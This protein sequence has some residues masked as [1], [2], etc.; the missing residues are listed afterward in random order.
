MKKTILSLIALIAITGFTTANYTGNVS[1]Y[2]NQNK[3]TWTTNLTGLGATNLVSWDY[4]RWVSVEKIACY[5]LTN[6][7]YARDTAMQFF[8]F[9]VEAFTRGQESVTNTTIKFVDLNTRLYTK[10]QL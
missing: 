7:C 8:G 4:S 3:T 6:M 9:D 10:P 1:D 2:Y 5:S